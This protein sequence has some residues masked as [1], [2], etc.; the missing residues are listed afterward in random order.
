MREILPASELLTEA[1]LDAV[2]RRSNLIGIGLVAHAWGVIALASVVV[3]AYPNPAVVLLAAM[4]IGS[5]QLGLVILMHDAAHGGLCKSPTLNRIL[6][7]CLCAWPM[8]ADTHTYRGYHLKHHT[9][10]LRDS[11]PDIVLTGHY[12]ISRAS[13]RRKL[14]RDLT[15]QSGFAQRKFQIGNALR[16]ASPNLR[17]R[18][19]HYWRELGPATVATV[20]IALLFTL[21][22][23]WWLFLACWLLPLLTWYQVVLRVR[24][25]AEHAVV[26]GLEDPFGVARTTYTN[27]IER[28][29]VAPYWVNYHLEHHLVMWAPCYRLPLLNRFLRDNGFGSRLQTTRGYLNVLR[30]VT[31]NAIDE[32]A[33]GGRGAIGSF[34]QGYK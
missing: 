20:V 11:D 13:L 7:Q 4:V 27:W 16:S 6:S 25:I 21:A 8:L 2:R 19:L 10:T 9:R 14:T 34:G 24:N 23:H 1:Q 18:A 5:R 30:E 26:R 33:S 3:A 12:P 28:A 22:G 29:F 31:T 15:G 17:D 32:N